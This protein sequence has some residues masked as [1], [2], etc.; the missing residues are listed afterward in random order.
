MDVFSY[1]YKNKAVIEYES[2]DTYLFH[3]RQRATCDLFF[4]LS[5]SIL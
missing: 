2:L 5:Y 1:I 4:R 3:Q